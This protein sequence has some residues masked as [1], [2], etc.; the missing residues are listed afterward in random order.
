[1]LLGKRHT[2]GGRAYLKGEIEEAAIYDQALKPQQVAGLYAQGVRKASDKEMLQ[3]MSDQQKA[4]Y[5]VLIKQGKHAQQ[6][7]APAALKLLFDRG[8]KDAGQVLYPWAKLLESDEQSLREDW[9]GIVEDWKRDLEK[10]QKFNRENFTKLW[11]LNSDDYHQW[12]RTGNG[13]NSMAAKP[14][15]FVIAEHGETFIKGILPGGVYSHLLSSKHAGL[16]VS[17]F[18]DLKSESLSVRFSGNKGGGL[19]IIVDNYPLGNNDTYPQIRPDEG[20]MRWFK[21]DTSYRKGSRAYIELAT[22]GELTRPRLNDSAANKKNVSPDKEGRSWFGISEVYLNKSPDKMPQEE[23]TPGA[24]LLKSKT[25]SSHD[26]LALRIKEVLRDGI[27]AWRD[28]KLSGE[29]QAF[30]NEFVSS[31][32]LKTKLAE[33]GPETRALVDHYRFLED[34]ISVPNRAPGPVE[35]D[36]YDARLMTRGNHHQLEDA[37]PRRFLQV[38][39][40]Q[41]HYNKGSGRLDLAYAVTDADNNTLFSRVIVN[42]VWHWLFG[43]GLVRTVDNFGRLGDKPTHPELLD[44]LAMRFQEDGYSIK[45]LIRLLVTSETWRQNH[46]V[47]EK[48]VQL[49]ASNQ[50]WSYMP[51]RRLEAEAIR[52]AMLQVSNVMNHDMYGEPRDDRHYARSIYLTERRNRPH[53]FLEVFDRPKTST[54][55]GQRDATNI[56]AQSL[57][58]MN[59]NFVRHLANRWAKSVMK[60]K[61]GTDS[62]SHRIKGVYEAAF[63]RQPTDQELSLAAE[64]LDGRNDEAGWSDYLQALFAS[65]EFIYLR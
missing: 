22:Y 30:L 62:Q 51:V 18:F 1:V 26:E 32:V 60:Q 64:Y 21:L 49:D 39:G 24:I 48:S 25:P 3:M 15:E 44:W 54:T 61:T 27:L 34:K 28:D 46:A 7:Q 41:Q 14:G 38:L 37:V 47:S 8:K 45:K 17:P 63:S 52:D 36:G 40:G 23:T 59:D 20:E 19:R 5:D 10:R 29:Q 58:M 9:S 6:E 16:L 11:D 12:T 43:Q 33:V 4:D 50:Y 2:G 53:P 42:R 13:L 56:P 55:R 31:G 65:K 35:A 57:S